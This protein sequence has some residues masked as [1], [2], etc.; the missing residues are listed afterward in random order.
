MH[1][2]DA[3]DP[4]PGLPEAVDP[5]TG[6][7]LA[8]SSGEHEAA[9]RRPDP[10]KALDALAPAR[11]DDPST[12][13]GREASVPDSPTEAIAQEPIVDPHAEQPVSG[14]PAPETK[15]KIK[16]GKR[17]RKALKAIQQEE[18]G[19]KKQE[20]KTAREKT[21]RQGAPLPAPEPTADP[22]SPFVSWLRTLPG[23]EYV[24]P[25]EEE[26]LADLLDGTH[27]S[28]ISETLADL[29]ATQGYTDRAVAMYEALVRKFPEKS[30]FFA[31]KI[32]ALR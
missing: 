12:G 3:N 29:L 26:G 2:S 9:L 10:L 17:V 24:H 6:N 16:A 32:K 11:P 21:A 25:Y 18:S 23:S 14:T 30:S 28:V 19:E 7:G 31:A 5:A 13:E 22:L 8:W 4:I 20:K 15:K 27:Q 1:P